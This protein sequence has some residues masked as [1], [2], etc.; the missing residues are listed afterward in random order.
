[1]YRICGI[2][3]SMT[4]K[5]N[6]ENEGSRDSAKTPIP[7]DEIGNSEAGSN[8]DTW[9]LS[10]RILQGRASFYVLCLAFHWLK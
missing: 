8:V 7:R 1:V 6:S 10:R 2:G 4:S 9:R 5:T 3:T